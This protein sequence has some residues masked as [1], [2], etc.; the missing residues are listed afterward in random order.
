MHCVPKILLSL[1]KLTQLGID[2]RIYIERFDLY[3][4]PKLSQ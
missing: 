2:L 3:I 4:T 1:N